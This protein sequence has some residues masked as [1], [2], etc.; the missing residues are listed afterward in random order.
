MTGWTEEDIRRQFQR[1]K[2][3]GWLQTFKKAAEKYDFPPEVLLA[4]ASRETNMRNIIGDGG[5]GYGIMQIDD[6]SFPEWSHSGLWKDVSAGIQKGALVLQSK[7]E[8]VRN[9][10]GKRLNVGGKSFT[11]KKNLTKAELLTTA[12]AAYNSGLWAYYDLSR[13]SNPDLHTTGRDYSTDTLRRAQVFRK[14]L[15]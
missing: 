13:T 5:H 7:L 11:G 15:G 9:G 12:V 10:Q 1:A 2:K 14:L 3:N 6:R 8:T 4:I